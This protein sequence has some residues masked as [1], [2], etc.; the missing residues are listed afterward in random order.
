MT[1]AI[2]DA[3]KK[4]NTEEPALGAKLKVKLT[5][6][7]APMRPGIEGAKQFSAVYTPSGNFFAGNGSTGC[8]GGEDRAGRRGD[9]R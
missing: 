3:L 1:G 8:S 4:A 5:G 6:T 9:P 7:A 2:A